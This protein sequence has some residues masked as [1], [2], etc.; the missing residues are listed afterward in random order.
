MEF[1]TYLVGQLFPEGKG[2]TVKNDSDY[3]EYFIAGSGLH[4]T[5]YE[6]AA[7][8]SLKYGITSDLPLF[9]NGRRSTGIYSNEEL[10]GVLVYLKGKAVTI[11]TMIWMQKIRRQVSGLWVV[12]ECGLSF[13]DESIY[14]H[15]MYDLNKKLIVQMLQ[16]QLKYQWRLKNDKSCIITGSETNPRHSLPAS[17]SYEDVLKFE[18]VHT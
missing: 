6:H 17:S 10:Y 12:D 14:C 7:R 11:P 13:N 4:F 9:P 18:L 8:T 1:L 5:V 16:N 3:E 15:T 2:F